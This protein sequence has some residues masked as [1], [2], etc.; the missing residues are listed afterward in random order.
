MNTEKYWQKGQ[1]I[2]ETALVI[3]LLFIFFFGIAEIARAWWLKN[4]LNNAARVG[5]RVAIVDATLSTLTPPVIISETC[6]WGGTVCQTSS[7]NE[8]IKQACRNITNEDLCKSIDGTTINGKKK[9]VA[10]TATDSDSSGKINAGDDIN[11]SVTGQFNSVVPN[12]S[13]LSFGL[14]PHN[15]TM[16]S[17]T[18][19]RY[20]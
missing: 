11:V 2:I 19:M 4:Q 1:T 15:I 16:T 10:V 12:L 5:V 14:I 17:D 3:I 18:S 7:A 9:E 6:N 20:E 13:S 8:A